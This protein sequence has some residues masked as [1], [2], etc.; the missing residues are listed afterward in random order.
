[1]NP[2][3]NLAALFSDQFL[4]TPLDKDVSLLRQ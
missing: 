2:A 4:M 1:M 3:A